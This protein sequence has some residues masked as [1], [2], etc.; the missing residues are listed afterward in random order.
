MKHGF[1]TLINTKNNWKYEGEFVDN[2]MNG[3][4]KYYWKDGTIFQ[5]KFINDQRT[6]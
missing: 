1:G 3:T 6:N 5:G 4:G 2:Q